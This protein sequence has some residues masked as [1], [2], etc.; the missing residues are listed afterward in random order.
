MIF[1][2]GEMTANRTPHNEFEQANPGLKAEDCISVAWVVSPDG[3]VRGRENVNYWGCYYLNPDLS[4]EKLDRILALAD[5]ISSDEGGPVAKL[6]VPGKDFKVENGEYIITRETDAD[7]NPLPM[8]TYYP[9]SEF[10]A[11]FINPQYKLKDT[12]DPHAI[13]LHEELDAAKRKYELD[14]LWNDAD[15][16]SYTADDYVKF[17]AAYE[18]NNLFA[19]I[20]VSNEDVETAWQRKRAEIQAAAQSVVDN[21][22]AALVK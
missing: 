12:A 2:K 15:R 22:N 20:V 19:E 9:S 11:Y 1:P 4:D 6:G 14:L 5:Y 13:K 10:F 8:E 7:G 17:N 16:T 18:V 3:K 21:M